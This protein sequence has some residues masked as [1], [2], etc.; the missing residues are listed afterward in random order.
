MDTL[1][2][3]VS[4]PTLPPTAILSNAAF[5][6]LWVA[7]GVSAFAFSVAALV[8]QWYVVRHLRLDASL[9]LVMIAGSLP[10]AVLMVIG[11]VVADRVNR[12]HVL[13]ASF[14]TRGLLTL[15]A[16]ALI[17][18]DR[19]SLAWVVAFA[20]V[21]GAIDAFFWPA[22]D[23][24][25]PDAVEKEQLTR[26]NSM[27]LITNQVASVFG[28]VVGGACVALIGY[29]SIFLAV[30][31]GLALS[32]VPL[33]GARDRYSPVRP[34]KREPLAAALRAGIA[35][36]LVTPV[37]RNVMAIQLATNALFAG[38][39]M[40]GLPLVVANGLHADAI[41]FSIAQ[42]ALA[43]GMVLAGLFMAWRPQKRRRLAKMTSYIAVTGVLVAALPHAASVG[44]LTVLMGLIGVC[45]AGNNVA[46]LAL[47]QEKT[48]QDKVGRVMSL[49]TVGWMGLNPLS[50]AIFSVFMSLG[51]GARPLMTAAGLCIALVSVVFLCSSAVVRQA[52]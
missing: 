15:S 33:I 23:A 40:V 6:R 45:I 42:S 46:M 22:R 30:G 41:A 29:Q 10:R 47:I 39:M 16:A 25:L 48:A 5:L 36:V 9:G 28:P 51:F 8:E 19:F 44:S 35:Y 18:M 20:L 31:A 13:A 52:D 49:N 43:A 38:P 4:A 27:L 7:S 14:I 17:A 2:R 11:G 3:T 21:Y 24:A 32:A 26:A 37:L 1:E 50:V 12:F 34:A